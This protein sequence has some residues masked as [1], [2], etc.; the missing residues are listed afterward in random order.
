MLSLAAA[1]PFA[2]FL[3]RDTPFEPGPGPYIALMGFGFLLAV[4]G[5]LAQSKTLIASGIAVI[6]G[7]IILVPIAV[8]LSTG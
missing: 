3:G 6:F 4:I 7:A 2:D 8:Y 5:H 1:L